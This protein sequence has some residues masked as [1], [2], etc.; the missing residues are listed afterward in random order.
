MCGFQ[1]MTLINIP[2]TLASTAP[3]SM[4]PEVSAQYA[5]SDMD[6]A[7]DKIDRATWISMFISIP[8][9]VGLAVL[10]G[11]ITRLLFPRTEGAAAQ[12]MMLGVITIILNGNSNI[13]NG[14]LQGIGKPN[15]PMINAAIALVVDVIAM[16]ILLFATDLGVYAIVV[17]M[18]IYAVVMCLLNERAMKQYMQ[19]KNP[20]RSAYLNPLL[21]SVPMAVV[22]GFSYYGIYKL[23]HSNFISLGIAV[24]LGMAA[25]FIVYLAVSKPSDEQFAM[26]PGGAYLKKIA[27]KLPF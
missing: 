21:A 17:A 18:I 27:G 19:Y 3:T 16:A 15:I 2:L 1:G 22:A 26:M 13:S 10:A 24:V 4:I 9:A 8:C 23:I 25:Y 12:L 20:W 14:V 7:R 6:S 5:K 11:P